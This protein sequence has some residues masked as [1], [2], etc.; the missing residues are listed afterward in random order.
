M[1]DFSQEGEEDRLLAVIG[2]CHSYCTVLREQ[3]FIA[4]GGS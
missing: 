4:R 1:C 2:G 3:S